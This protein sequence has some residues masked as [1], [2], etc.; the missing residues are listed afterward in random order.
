VQAQVL[1]IEDDSEIL[2]LITLYLSRE[3][4]RVLSAPSAEKGLGILGSGVP[5]D[6]VL[7]DLNLPGIDGYEFLQEFR[8]TYTQPVVVVSA[9]VDDADMV[10][11]FGYGADDFVSK[12]FSPKVL[13]ARVRAHIRREQRMREVSGIKNILFGDYVF[14]PED[15]LLKK[16]GERV[17]LSPKEMQLLAELATHRGKPM[18]QDEL[19]N[20]IW[21][22][23]YGEL[24]TVSVHIQRLRKKIEDDPTNPLYIL[25]VYG[26]GYMFADEEGNESL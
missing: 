14:C 7:L 18:S 8:K 17:G 24:N 6:L 22:N 5:V 4:I 9:R 2:D 15:S 3:Q 20:R 16:R 12:P 1:V 26:F 19:Y 11:G 13:S 21:G 23:S 10:L 25:T